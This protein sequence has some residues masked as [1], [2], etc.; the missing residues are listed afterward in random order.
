MK[1][2]EFFVL[3]NRSNPPQTLA[4]NNTFDFVLPRQAALDSVAVQPPDTLPL[5]TSVSPHGHRGRYG[6][7]YPIRPGVTK[8]RVVYHLPHSGKVSLTPTVLHPVA[9]MA[10]MVPQS[11]RMVTGQPD[12]FA[13]HGEQ[14]GLS[15]YVANYLRPG[16]SSTFSLS[17][18]GRSNTS[19]E[20]NAMAGGSNFSGTVAHSAPPHPFVAA[21]LDQQVISVTQRNLFLR[22]AFL[23][24]A[25]TGLLIATNAFK[26][27]H[28]DSAEKP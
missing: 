23:M 1:I 3:S 14:N 24:T 5:R 2:T 12:A 25:I 9:A 10:L 17:G 27:G 21:Q 8:V 4:A 13:Y 15:V 11:M 20:A 16:T 6:V 22:C 18:T 7:S 19:Y 28:H 26:K